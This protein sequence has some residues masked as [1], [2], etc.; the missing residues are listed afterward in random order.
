MRKKKKHS[1]FSD[2]DIIEI[3]FDIIEA[4]LFD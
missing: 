3:I 4:I 2:F 1:F